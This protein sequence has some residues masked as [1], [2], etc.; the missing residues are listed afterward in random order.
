MKRPPRLMPMRS[1]VEHSLTPFR[2]VVMTYSQLHRPDQQ[3]DK[4]R[5]SQYHVSAEKSSNVSVATSKISLSSNP[6]LASTMLPS[7][8]EE[9]RLPINHPV[10]LQT[11]QLRRLHIS[12]KYINEAKELYFDATARVFLPRMPTMNVS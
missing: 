4:R 1:P 3:Q 8:I 11:A 6:S 12:E 10:R 2:P 9:L 7:V 5:P